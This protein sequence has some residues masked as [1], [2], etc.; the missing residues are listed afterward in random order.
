MSSRKLKD[1]E[2]RP[3]KQARATKSVSVECN[4][5]LQ[6]E[7]S[8]D[9]KAMLKRMNLNNEQLLLKEENPALF[10]KTVANEILRKDLEG[11]LVDNQ[12]VSVNLRLMNV[13]LYNFHLVYL[14]DFK[15]HK[16]KSMMT[17]EEV[18]LNKEAAKLEK[19]VATAQELC[20]EFMVLR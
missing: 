15:L 8:E 13:I 10:W 14:H 16:L 9:D 7:T 20:N 18:D 11:C 6:E 17:E 19:L 1:E 5:D 2:T 12:E 3:P 4:L